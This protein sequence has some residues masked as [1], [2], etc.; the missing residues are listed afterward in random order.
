MFKYHFSESFSFIDIIFK[1]DF[2]ENNFLK[3]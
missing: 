1:T 3:E 2:F